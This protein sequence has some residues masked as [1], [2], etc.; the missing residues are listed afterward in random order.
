MKF[1]SK[2]ELDSFL[3]TL[4]F[5]GEGCQGLCFLDKKTNQVYKIYSEYYYDLEDAG[6]IDSDIMEFGQISNSTFIWPNG[7]ICVDDIIVGY[8][9]SYV[10]AKN[11]YEFNDPFKVNLDNLSYAV[12]S[13]SDKNESS[14]LLI[15]GAS[16][17]KI[18]DDN[19][20]EAGKLIKSVIKD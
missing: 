13:L 9:H 7:V 11:F 6:Y 16:E 12:W 20:S 3:S 14:A 15:P 18:I 5:I 10:N 19:L 17:N 8:T 2:K 4:K 1:K